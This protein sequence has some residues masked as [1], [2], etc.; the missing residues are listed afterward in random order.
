M[1]DS[2]SGHAAAS[3]SDFTFDGFSNP[4]FTQVPNEFLDVLAPHLSEAELRVGLY[5]L[6]RTWGFGKDADTISFG[7]MIEGIRRQKPDG[8]W[9]ILDHGTGLSRKGVWSGVNGLQ[10]KGIIDVE[11]RK[12]PDGNNEINIYRP[13]MRPGVVPPGRQESYHGAA[14]VVSSGNQGSFLGKPGVV[15]SGN[16]QKKDQQKKATTAAPS[17]SSEPPIHLK[18][19]VASRGVVASYRI[20]K[21]D[22]PIPA[23][24]GTPARQVGDP[25]LVCKLVAAGVTEKVARRLV[26]T[27]PGETIKIQLAALPFR[28]KVKEPGAMLVE[29]IRESW[30]MPK[31]Y[32]DAVS[33][34]AREAQA[35]ARRDVAHRN[36]QAEEVARQERHQK[37]DHY[38][39][40]LTAEDQQRLEQEASKQIRGE[41]SVWKVRDIPRAVLNATMRSLVAERLGLAP[42]PG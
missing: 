10:S 17:A 20:E 12:T 4:N 42:D 34:A 40:G 8:T 7:Q 11:K 28:S 6:R 9:E 14:R 37:V 16:P 36:R 25:V 32:T 33:K 41:G 26:A 39:A 24:E 29:A 3:S 19:P 23:E 5:I 15:S 38:F 35:H 2:M 30:T 31:A 21:T 18:A 27:C 22:R 13:R 1:P